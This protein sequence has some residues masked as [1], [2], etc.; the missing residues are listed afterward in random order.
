M[1]KGIDISRWQG[2]I[3]WPRVRQHVEFAII[4]IG[5]SDQGYYPD[6]QAVRNVLEARSTGLPIGFYVY[7]GGT[8]APADEIAHIKNLVNNIG[9]LRP[10]E[11]FVLDWE[12]N[13]ANEVGY[14]HAIAK[15][16]VDSGFPA[17]LIY[18]NLSYVR[19]QNWKP[20]VDLGCG[21]WVAAWGNNDDIADTPPP[22]DEWPMWAIWQYSSTG[23]VPGIAGRVDMNYFNGTVEQFKKYGGGKTLSMP[24][25]VKTSQSIPT[26]TNGEYIVVAG[27]NLSAIAARHGKSWQE[28]WALNRDRVSNPNKIFP[29]LKLRI[30]GNNQP[31]APAAPPA[32]VDNTRYHTV[33]SG[34]NL[35]VIAQKYNLPSYIILWEANKDQIPDPNMIRPGQ[36]L[37][38]P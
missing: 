29:G 9:G 25:T 13:N 8:G 21:L 4:K 27:D 16:L 35:S 26:G 23:S 3:D 17:P 31:A 32:P 2:I 37:R 10:G 19:R 15:G 12:E 18:M 7:L 34:E 38:I 5:G 33:V 11:L 6:G 20:L 24:V 28:L 14:V 22:S 30:W 36:K 1:I